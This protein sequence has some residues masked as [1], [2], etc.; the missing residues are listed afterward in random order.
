[1]SLKS[2]QVKDTT[3]KLCSFKGSYRLVVDRYRKACSCHVCGIVLKDDIDMNTFLE[4]SACSNCVDT[5]YYP[6]ADKWKNGWRPKIT[7]K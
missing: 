5:Y 2:Q 6:N 1:M 7:R 4:H 3:Q